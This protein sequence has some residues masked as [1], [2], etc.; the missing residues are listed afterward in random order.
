MIHALAIDPGVT[1]G[2]CQAIIT[3]SKVVLRV[4]QEEW[5]LADAWL[6]VHSFLDGGGSHVVIEDFEYR[7]GAQRTGLNLFPV[8]LIGVIE[9]LWQWSPRAFSLHKQTAAQ[10]KGYYRDNTLKELG[11]WAKGKPHGRDSIR[12]MLHWLTFGPGAQYTKL[13]KSE[14]V[15]LEE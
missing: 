7:Q 14:L 4:G 15:L 3:D 6:F 13:D 12:H 8:K 2:Y 5:T 9:L 11:V 1:T 10:A